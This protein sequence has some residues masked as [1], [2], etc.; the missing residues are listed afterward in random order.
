MNKTVFE[1]SAAEVQALSKEQSAVTHYTDADV[2]RLVEQAEEAL[3]YACVAG[4]PT[5]PTKLS[6]ALAPFRAKPKRY[7]MP[8]WK[9]FYKA[10]EHQYYAHWTGDY[11][12]LDINARDKNGNMIQVNEAEYNVIRELLAVEDVPEQ[13]PRNEKPRNLSARG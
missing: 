1:L 12:C 5:W 2:A 9:D 4:T 7:T 6:I 13:K 3:Q 10:Q 11:V 8:E